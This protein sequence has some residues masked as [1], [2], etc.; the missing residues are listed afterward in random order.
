MAE[1]KDR[2]VE[3]EEKVNESR[4]DTERW[5]TSQAPGPE[6]TTKATV[7]RMTHEHPEQPFGVFN[8]IAH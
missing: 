3:V 6:E 7:G 5:T 8:S 1:A 4:R 2:V